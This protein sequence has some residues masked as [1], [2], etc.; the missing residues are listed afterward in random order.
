VD[1]WMGGWVDGWMGGWMGGGKGE[2]WPKPCMHIWIIKEKKKVESKVGRPV[3]S[4]A[5]EH[6]LPSRTLI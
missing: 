5:S 1:G 6:R 2:E 3:G 4:Q